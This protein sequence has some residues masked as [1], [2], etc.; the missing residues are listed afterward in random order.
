M[1]AAEGAEPCSALQ[2]IVTSTDCR[3]KGSVINVI[4]R[5]VATN[6]RQQAG[7]PL[8]SSS[9]L[10]CFYLST[11]SSLIIMFLHLLSSPL[12]Y[13]PLLFSPSAFLSVIPP[14][15]CLHFC[16]K[17]VLLGLASIIYLFI[18]PSFDIFPLLLSRAPFFFLFRLCN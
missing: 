18:S 6:S 5:R 16:L 2:C 8:W 10:Q 4:L 1:C 15:P 13:S 17:I 9:S 11:L 12:L 3:L 14:C 7:T